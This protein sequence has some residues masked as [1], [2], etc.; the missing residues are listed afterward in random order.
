MPF[1]SR[2]WRCAFSLIELLVV[3]AIIGIL[4]ALLLPVL[5]Q[6]RVSAHRSVDQA[7]LRQL[8][9][10][11]VKYA[12]DDDGE[13]PQGLS[14]ADD[15]TPD[16]TCSIALDG[17]SATPGDQPTALHMM[18]QSTYLGTDSILESPAMDAPILRDVGPG[19]GDVCH[20]SYRYNE[21]GNADSGVVLDEFPNSSKILESESPADAAL[22]WTASDFRRDP[23]TGDTYQ[24]T[25]DHEQMAWPYGDAGYVSRLDGSIVLVP[26]YVPFDSFFGD[27]A[28]GSYPAPAE[29]WMNHDPDAGLGG[30]DFAVRKAQ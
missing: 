22:F 19:V 29:Q 3:I 12:W 10:T 25:V 5:R 1:S 26:N 28:S 9:I 21:S 11:T 20:Y 7:N 18:A 8:H 17:D 15:A 16:Y 13:L 24:V 14:E 27:N 2:R 23:T 30:I 4:I 6:S